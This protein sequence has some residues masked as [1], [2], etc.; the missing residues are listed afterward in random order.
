[1]DFTI[2]KPTI[3]SSVRVS[4]HDPNGSFANVDKN[5]SVLFKIQRQ[6]NTTFNIAQEILQNQKGNKKSNL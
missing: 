2:T 3:M 6:M 5:S 1:V 4:I